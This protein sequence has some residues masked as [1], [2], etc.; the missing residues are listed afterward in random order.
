L[1]DFYDQQ[2]KLDFKLQC[3]EYLSQYEHIKTIPIE[4]MWTAEDIESGEYEEII[5][6]A[7]AEYGIYD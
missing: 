2:S 4:P 7:F 6:K 5:R 3:E 1:C